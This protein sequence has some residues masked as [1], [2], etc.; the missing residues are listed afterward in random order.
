MSNT[1]PTTANGHFPQCMR[2]EK[3]W[4]AVK[5]KVGPFLG[6]DFCRLGS[7]YT[8]AVALFVIGCLC[9]IKIIPLGSGFGLHFS[10]LGIAVAII[11]AIRNA[12]SDPQN[13]M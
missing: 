7:P 3:W 11:T 8:L 2:L 5:S 4:G 1:P 6:K 10:L 13:S 12:K 9:S